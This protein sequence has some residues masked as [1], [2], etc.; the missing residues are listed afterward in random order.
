LSSNANGM[1]AQPNTLAVHYADSNGNLPAR[2]TSASSSDQP[3]PLASDASK[4]PLAPPPPPPV[5]YQTVFFDGF[6]LTFD[7][8]T[9]RMDLVQASLDA[10]SSNA[11]FGIS[12]ELTG[13][14]LL[15]NVLQSAGGSSGG[16]GG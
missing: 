5:E 7:F 9:G 14:R 15:L 4:P 1:A 8:L 11:S 10:G 12:S 2:S 6:Q 16:K 3:A 13:V